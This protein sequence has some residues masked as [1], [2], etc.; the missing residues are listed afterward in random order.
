MKTAAQIL[1]HILLIFILKGMLDRGPEIHG[2]RSDLNLR[3]N[4]PC[5]LHGL[6]G[7]ADNHMITAVTARLL[8]GNIILLALHTHVGAV[9]DHIRHLIDILH[10][11]AYD[12][13]SRDIFN[14]FLNFIQRDSFFL[15]L[16][17][18]AGYCLEP[19]V[20]LFNRGI[21]SGSSVFLNNMIKFNN[22]LVY[23]K[24]IRSKNLSPELY[25]HSFLISAPLLSAY[26]VCGCSAD[27]YFI[28]DITTFAT[29]ASFTQKQH[30]MP[31]SR[32]GMPLCHYPS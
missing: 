28:P 15:S 22:Q 19:S 27:I 11:L 23:R 1:G 17:Q 8:I 12:A 3:V 25:F 16:F 21:D 24:F 9:P 20:H 13:D 2:K 10:E 32:H 6:Y 18:Y 4:L 5:P 7:I 26:Q 30:S 31:E 14:I 29:T